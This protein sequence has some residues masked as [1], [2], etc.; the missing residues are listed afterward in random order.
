MK[1]RLLIAIL[2]MLAMTGVSKAQRYDGTLH[3]YETNNGLYSVYFGVRAGV[4]TSDIEGSK[5]LLKDSKNRTSFNLGVVAG[6]ELTESMPLF[7]EVGLSYV[8]KGGKTPKG[9]AVQYN[10]HVNYFEVPVVLKYI[11]KVS[12]DITVQPLVGVW[13]ALGAGGHTEVAGIKTLS[14]SDN[15]F[16]KTDA[17][18]RVGCGVTYQQYILE[19]DYDYGL[20]NMAHKALGTSRTS[21][22]YLTLGM[23]F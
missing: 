11:A 7:A 19:L 14:F 13:A 3:D 4:V 18:I 12:D 16:K 5:S 6:F 1:R 22:A 15:L 17:G 2:A 9:A 8:Q 10:Y 23:N 21:S 20:V